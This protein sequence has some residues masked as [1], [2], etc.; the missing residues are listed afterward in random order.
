MVGLTCQLV[1]QGC[2]KCVSDLK[3]CC[4]KVSLCKLG[5]TTRWCYAKTLALPPA[6]LGTATPRWE[7]AGLEEEVETVARGGRWRERKKRRNK[8]NKEWKEIRKLSQISLW[9]DHSIRDMPANFCH[10]LLTKR[11]YT[12]WKFKPI[13]SVLNAFQCWQNK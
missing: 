5:T 12:T 13:I 1:R 11:S 2:I 9:I 3:Q 10:V 7:W 8:K 4:W 6:C